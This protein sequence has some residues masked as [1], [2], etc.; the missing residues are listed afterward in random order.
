MSALDNVKVTDGRLLVDAAPLSQ[1]TA[2][3][4]RSFIATT[5]QG[6]GSR[7]LL[8][9]TA[10]LGHMLLLKNGSSKYDWV[11]ERFSFYIEN[12]T[13]IVYVDLNPVLGTITNNVS[14]QVYSTRSGS[15]VKPDSTYVVDS[16]EE[17]GTGMGGVTEGQFIQ[18]V[19]GIGGSGGF[20]PWETKG[21]LILPSGTS[22]GIAAID[23]GT[24]EFGCSI[25]FSEVER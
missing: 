23:S 1:W 13:T 6:S 2:K 8:T 25:E 19:R 18:Q 24:G 3:G 21:S 14:D 10:T 15:S 4:D 11:I 5:N 12:S 7:T 20:E 16:W 9:L 22:L 17:T